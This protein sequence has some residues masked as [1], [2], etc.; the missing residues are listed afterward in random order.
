M[1]DFCAGL[2]IGFFAGPITLIAF[3]LVA[4]KYL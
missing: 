2:L 3:I 1:I 4:Q